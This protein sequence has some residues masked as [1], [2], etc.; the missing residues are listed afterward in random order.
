MRGA[1]YTHETDI[2]KIVDPVIVQPWTRKI[3]DADS[4][5][6]FYTLI[7]EL[8]NFK[9]LDPACG[10]G[11]FLFIAFKEMKLLEKKLLNR[12][13]AHSTKKADAEVLKRFLQEEPFVSTKQFYGIDIKEDAV[14]LAKVTLMVAKELWVTQNTE[15][16][17]REAALPLDNLDNNIIC[18]DALLTEDGKPR[19]WP[20]V[21]AIIGNPPYQS[22]NRMQ[23]EFGA[24]YVDK[25]RT[26]YPEVPGR[27]DFCVYWF[28]KAHKNLKNGC[29]AGLVGTNTIRQNYSREGSLDH[30]VKNGGTIID[31]VSTEPWSGAAAVHVSIACWKKGEEKGSKNLYYPNTKG[32]LELHKVPVINS[33]LSLSV[34]VVAAF[35]L[36]CNKDPKKCFQGQTHGHEGFLLT[37][38]QAKDLIR[39]NEK[40]HE[41]L[42]PFLVGDE[43]VGNYLS[44]PKRFVI[45]FSKMDMIYA[46]SFKEPFNILQEKVLPDIQEKAELEKKGITKANGREAWLKMWWKMWRR[47]EDML[48]STHD[49]KRY[50]SCARVTQRPIFEFI[51]TEIRPN[52]KVMVFCFDDDYSFGIIQ[53]KLHW[54]WFLEKCTTLGETPNYNTDAIWNTFPWPQNPTQKQIEKVASAAKTLKAERDKILISHHYSLRDLY[55]I[56]EMPGKNPIKDLHS[57]LDKAVIE[58]YNFETLNLKDY[59][60][61]ISIIS[62]PM[63][64]YWQWNDNDY[65]FLKY[66]LALN[67]EIH[68]KE[69]NNEPVQAPGLPGWVKNKEKFISDDCVKFEG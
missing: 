9:V 26:T 51:S 31:A 36:N 64:I 62:E 1:H 69:L 27:A 21:D 65:D 25:L 35:I 7:R 47:R 14:E 15:D 23:A 38:N 19:Q 2:M 41:V 22:K 57:K 52:D 40:N 68:Q 60:K 32:N 3:D 37:I 44:Q 39:K 28:Y 29:Y 24:D 61:D 58:A 66:L 56:V 50:I 10:S 17:D 49:I 8:R 42:K 20:E 18:A 45:D 43:L 54:K 30:I 67:K 55:R 59:S 48:N 13:R 34:D 11:N 4:L 53:S 16:H 6:E 46:S 5:D 12:I 63:P 33:S